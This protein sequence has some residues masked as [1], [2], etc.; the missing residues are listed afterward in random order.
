MLK[1]NNTNKR[2][3]VKCH[4]TQNTQANAEESAVLAALLCERRLV[5]LLNHRPKRP[6]C[7]F[8]N[9]EDAR[10]QSTALDKQQLVSLLYE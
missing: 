5:Q 4:L 7:C 9:V 3:P 2:V 1:D 6:T 8:Y 10:I